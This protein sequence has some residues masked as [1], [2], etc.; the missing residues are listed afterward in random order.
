MQHIKRASFNM[1]SVYGT[2]SLTVLFHTTFIT[3]L[4]H[5]S[6]GRQQRETNVMVNFYYKT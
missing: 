2:N 3:V 5:F 4:H 6:I 1:Q